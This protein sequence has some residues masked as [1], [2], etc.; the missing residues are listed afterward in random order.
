VRKNSQQNKTQDLGFS[1]LLRYSHRLVRKTQETQ[2]SLQECLIN[3]VSQTA[4]KQST[5]PSAP[6]PTVAQSDY[7]QN[8][9]ILPREPK[10]LELILRDVD[11]KGFLDIELVWKLRQKEGLKNVRGKICRKLKQNESAFSFEDLVGE[12]LEAV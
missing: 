9:L 10:N 7:F 4:K 1:E 5:P 3:C 6:F 8:G 12:L 11:A 2:S